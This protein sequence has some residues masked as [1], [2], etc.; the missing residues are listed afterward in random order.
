MSQVTEMTLPVEGMTCAACA[1]R[2]EKTVGKLPGVQ[3]VH[4]NLASERAHV[5]LGGETTWK[6]VVDRIVKTGYTVPLQEADLVITGMTC[7]ACAARIEKVVGR[8]P[9]VQSASVNLASERAKVTYVPGL[10]D[11]PD[12]IRAVEKAGYG[13]TLASAANR[14]EEKRRKDE[15]YRRDW[16]TFGFSALLTLPLLVQMFVM[17]FGGQPFLPGWASL[18]LATPVQ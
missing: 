17:L 4:V 14:D 7:A 9:G 18:I 13:A 5:V 11:T 2:I 12:L 8:L 3:A 15:A 10:I 16:V 6:D 1:A